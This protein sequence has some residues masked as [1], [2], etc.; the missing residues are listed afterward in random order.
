MGRRTNITKGWL[1]GLLAGLLLPALAV[2]SSGGEASGE[3][4]GQ[5]LPLWSIIPFIGILLSIAI[6][7]LVAPEFWHH[8][9]PKISA[10]WALA[11]AVP[12]LIVY[13][14][15]AFYEIMHIILVD[16]VPFIIVLWGLYTVGGGI[17]LKGR[18]VGTPAV[19]VILLLVGTILASWTGTT[20][21]AMLLIR[22]V[23]RAN[24]WR[25]KKM[26]IIIF[27]IFLVANIGGSLTPLGD[28]PLLL[29]FFHGVPFFWTLRLIVPMSFLAV[30]LLVIFYLLDSYFMRKDGVAPPQTGER[31][32]I[33]LEGVH[34][35]LF[36][37]G[38]LFFV[39]LS[40]MLDLREVNILGVH[41]PQQDILRVLGI[42]LMGL[43]SLRTT[44]WE[45]R[46][47]NDFTWFPIQE[48]AYLFAGIFI[49]IVPAL[50]ILKAGS[51]GALAFIINS[52]EKPWHYFWVTGT[53]SS[54]LDNAPT[55]LT[56]FNTALGKLHLTESEVSLFLAGSS[57]G[58]ELLAS[59]Q[60]FEQLLVA[61]SLGAVFMGA[62]TYIGNAPNFMV[63][64]IAEEN[65]IKMPSF[66][67]YMFWSMCI[68]VPIFILI[69]FVFLR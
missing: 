67:G 45:L 20:G 35:F 19:N 23:I 53:L 55:Y 57:T 62:N 59:L 5:I 3:H 30:I 68:L 52:V 1:G 21:A 22:P 13:K 10:F 9:F 65:K 14:G 34:N 2:A 63:R 16:Y 33:R 31:D 38:I 41:I 25:K 58:G 50:A 54:F 69:T 6:F 61:V 56:F 40:G 12:F 42:I 44:S 29:G 51:E 48:V 7:P 36:L 11:F 27:F 46:R 60:T 66:F 15:E 64:S 28:P 18:L 26:H 8:H 37:V 49:T 47:A 24:A 4:L 17:V 32:P 39:L 43:L